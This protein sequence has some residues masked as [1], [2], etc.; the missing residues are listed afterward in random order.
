MITEISRIVVLLVASGALV[1]S[2]LA[3]P[4]LLGGKETANVT[5][6]WVV[7][8]ANFAVQAQQQTLRQDTSTPATT[9]VLVKIVSA[10]SQVV[11]GM[12]YFLTLEVTENGTP[13]TAVAVVWRRLSGVHQLTSWK[14]Q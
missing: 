3:A 6:A 10:E 11:A 13:R 9:L 8:A 12:N 4:P 14:W 1:G 5:N 7:A 2:A